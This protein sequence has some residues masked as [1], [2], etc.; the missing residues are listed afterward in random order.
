VAYFSPHFFYSCL[1]RNWNFRKLFIIF[2]KL[3]KM[4]PDLFDPLNQGMFD[5]AQL[6]GARTT[7]YSNVGEPMSVVFYRD[8]IEPLINAALGS[9]SF[10]T[11]TIP[12]GFIIKR[13]PTQEFSLSIAIWGDDDYP[14]ASSETKLMEL[15][16]KRRM[17]NEIVQS[18]SPFASAEAKQAK[19]EV[20]YFTMQQIKD[21]LKDQSVQAIKFRRTLC[22][23]NHPN[24]GISC[25]YENLVAE[26][27]DTG[28]FEKL[29]TGKGTR[30]P[31][32]TNYTFGFACP[33]NWRTVY[34]DR[35]AV[36]PKYI[37]KPYLG[38]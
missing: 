12:G 22:L 5:F 15:S 24:G 25:W 27:Y 36:N 23:F 18:S 9:V 14:S 2:K 1:H 31:E 19:F 3:K 26:P 10:T 4:N 16:R 38:R 32:I 29:I 8:E 20:V 34:F 11:A 13:E 6:I 35:A 33:P 21:L 28:F 7:G 37:S 30:G 17:M